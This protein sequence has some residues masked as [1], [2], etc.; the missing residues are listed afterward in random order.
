MRPS[1]GIMARCAPETCGAT[2]PRA[3]AGAGGHRTVRRL[4]HVRD[5][6]HGAP[7][8]SRVVPGWGEGSAVSCSSWLSPTFGA[9]MFNL[10]VVVLPRLRSRD[11]VLAA[12]GGLIR[13]LSGVGL[14]M[15]AILAEG[16]QTRVPQQ[17][18]PPEDWLTA[19]GQRLPFGGPSP[20]Q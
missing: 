19:S 2:S 3:S 11:R 9:W 7:V 13:R 8:R 18:P 1:C 10:L 20:P 12:G 17:A 15:P 5:R 14:A 4:H 16:A 6:S